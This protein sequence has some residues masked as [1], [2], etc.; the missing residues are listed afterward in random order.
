MRDPDRAWLTAT[1]LALIESSEPPRIRA[2]SPAQLN[3]RIARARRLWDKY[4]GL[5]REQERT[6]KKTRQRDRPQPFPNV[7]TERKA[8]IFAD[9]LERVERRLAQL[10]REEHRRSRPQAKPIPKSPG[11][12]VAQRGTIR[13]KKQQGRAS[14]EAAL[15]PPITRQFQKSKMLAIQ[16]HISARGKRRQATCDAR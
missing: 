3:D 6:I 16:G 9:V 5:A 11:R 8:Q 13:R 12:P 4:R 10:T 15:A 1:E 2:Y 14:N 7:G